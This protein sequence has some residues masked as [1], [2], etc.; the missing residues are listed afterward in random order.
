[1]YSLVTCFVIYNMVAQTS[2]GQTFNPEIL[3]HDYMKYVNDPVIKP[4]VADHSNIS[5]SKNIEANNLLHSPDPKHITEDGCVM[6]IALYKNNIKMFKR[7]VGSLRHFGYNGHI[8]LGVLNT[9]NQDEVVY[10]RK[11]YVTLYAI[12]IS[13][14][15]QSAVGDGKVKGAIRNKCS[16]DIPDLKLEWGRFE[17]ARRWL[18]AC[19]ACTGWSLVVDVRDTFFQGHPVRCT[20]LSVYELSLIVIVLMFCAVS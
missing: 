6:G 3:Q 18:V 14:C 16:K 2:G 11:K 13:S 17:M 10:L 20:Y 4:S 12:E 9:I 19:K 7:F 5:L 8:I 15:A 1:M